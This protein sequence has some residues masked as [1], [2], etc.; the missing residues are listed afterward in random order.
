[1]LLNIQYISVK[2]P[3]LWKERLLILSLGNIIRN[4]CNIDKENA[5]YVMEGGVSDKTDRTVIHRI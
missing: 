4:G 3:C 1:M 2:Y 5:T